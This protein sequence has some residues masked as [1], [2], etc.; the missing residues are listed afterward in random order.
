MATDNFPVKA[1]VGRPRKAVTPAAPQPVP[2]IV[3]AAPE[4]ELPVRTVIEAAMA[5]MVQPVVENTAKVAEAVTDA[6]DEVITETQAVPM[7]APVATKKASN[8]VEQFNNAAQTAFTQGS[9]KARATLDKTVR[10]LE[11]AGEFAKGNVEALMA[12]GK[13]AT[14]GVETLAQT[15]A[16]YSKKSLEA[17]SAHLQTL[18][19]TRTPADAFKLQSDFAKSQFDGLVAEMS[20]STEMMMKIMGDVFAPLSN[21]VALATEKAKTAVAVAG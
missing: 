2:F 20:K 3:E 5:P 7:I 11:E 6:A 19:S 8:M 10:S 4:A 15:A 16:D 12:S 1:K 13:A 18:A 21:R 17:G 14:A 9:D